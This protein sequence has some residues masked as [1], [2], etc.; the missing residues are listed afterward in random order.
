VKRRKWGISKNSKIYIIKS[1]PIDRM[2]LLVQAPQEG[3][4]K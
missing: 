3:E 1:L 2:N 4:L